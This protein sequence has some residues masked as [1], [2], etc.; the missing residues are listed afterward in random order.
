MML[1]PIIINS[2]TAYFSEKV[3]D[4]YCSYDVIVFP[5]LYMYTHNNIINR[6]ALSYIDLFAKRKNSVIGLQFYSA[7]NMS[8]TFHYNR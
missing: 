2:L 5:V 6:Y 4:V 7:Y 3:I 8:S 1:G